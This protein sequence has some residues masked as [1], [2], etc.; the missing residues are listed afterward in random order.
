MNATLLAL[1]LG[2]SAPQAVRSVPQEGPYEVVVRSKVMVPMRDGVRLA[3]D[4]YFPGKDGEPASGKYPTVLEKTPYGRAAAQEQGHYFASRGY[5]FIMADCRGAND[6]EGVL[7]FYIND[8]RDGHDLVEWIARQPWSNGAVG[9]YG[10]SHGGTAQFATALARPP[11]LRAQFLVNAP[12]DYADGGGAWNGGAWMGDHNLSHTLGRILNAHAHDRPELKARVE[13]ALLPANYA[14]WLEI[15]ASRHF[16]L[17]A[18]VPA[19]V[20]WFRDWLGHPPGDAYWE[21]IGYNLSA[22][23][24]NYPDVPIYFVGGW[25]D[26]VQRP[27]MRAYAGLK[28]VIRSPKKMVSGPWIH[29][30]SRG[31]GQSHGQTDFGADADLRHVVLAERWME[32][33]LKG[34]DNGVTEEPPVRIFVMGTGDGHK[35]PEGRLFHGGYWRDEPE[36]PL[37]RAAVTPYYL[38]AGGGLSPEP[39]RSAPASG[40]G[41]DPTDPVPTIHTREGGGWDQRCRKEF[42]ACKDELPLAARPD[43]LVFR[44]PTLEEAVEVTGPLRVRFFAASDAP[45]TDFTFKLVDEYPASPDFPAGF[46]LILVDGLIRARYRNGYAR[47]EPMQPGQVYE[48]VL[49]LPP[50]SNVFK[51]GHRIRLDVSSSNFPKFDVNPNTGEKIQFHTHTRVAYNQ[52][53]HDPEH[54]SYFELPVVRPAAGPAG[55]A[56]A[57]PRRAP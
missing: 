22:H 27:F 50:T 28:A 55:A 15:P 17:F 8:S 41:F 32:R 30:R 48:F 54:A 51:A 31:G 53:Y 4:I 14:R 47:P 7:Y 24:D 13:E 49:E 29:G 23:R 35:T 16:E 10:V 34:I 18:D 6:S 19:A 56:S 25:Y 52:I 5:V 40:Y 42:I 2:L 37:R 3:L 38:H 9:T 43:V 57:A 11:H 46:A 44:T 1:L 36:W 12:D 45:D 26:H 39:P 21:Q 33:W 20:A